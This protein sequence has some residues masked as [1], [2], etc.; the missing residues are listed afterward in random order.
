VLGT[1]SEGARD[2]DTHE[3]LKYGFSRYKPQTPVKKGGEVASPKLSWR[4]DHLALNAARA[5]PVDIRAGQRVATKVIAPGEVDGPVE[6]GQKLGRVT[7][8]VDG[9]PAGASPLIAAESVAAATLFQ[10]A[11]AIVLSPFVLL[12]IGL[13]V[14]V[15][16]VLLA[17]R[18]DGGDDEP[19][20]PRRPRRTRS[21][22]PRSAE[23]RERMRVERMRRRSQT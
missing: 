21:D 5:V 19:P 1:P 7:V 18:R 8:S 12:L 23:E 16:G 10:K 9:R 15:V 4:N 6:R 2:A 13:I 3:L 20:R 11:T 17:R 22:Q 14:I